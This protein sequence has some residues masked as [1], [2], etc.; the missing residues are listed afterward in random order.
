MHSKLQDM[1]NNRIIKIFNM[2][3]TDQSYYFWRIETLLFLV[4]RF[5][6]GV[7]IYLTTIKQIEALVD[8]NS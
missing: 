2:A 7:K 5:V 6:N 4:V 1:R 8:V 3:N